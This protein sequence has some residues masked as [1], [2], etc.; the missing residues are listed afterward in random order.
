MTKAARILRNDAWEKEQQRRDKFIEDCNKLSYR[1]RLL[2][3][4]MIQFMVEN[5]DDGKEETNKLCLYSK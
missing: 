2:I 3:L 5:P 1:N 4:S